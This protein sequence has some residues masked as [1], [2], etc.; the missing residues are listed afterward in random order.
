MLYT[1]TDPA[2]VLFMLSN[3]HVSGNDIAD[4]AIV[5]CSFLCLSGSESASAQVFF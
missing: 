5:Y 2:I 4:P 3:V 1:F